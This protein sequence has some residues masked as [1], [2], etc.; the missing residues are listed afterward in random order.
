[1]R[2]QIART[3]PKVTVPLRRVAIHQLQDKVR[4]VWVERGPTNVLRSGGD[5]FVE[6]DRVGLG[7]VIRRQAGEHFKDEDSK[8]IPVD[9]FVIALLADDFGGKII[10]GATERPGGVRAEFRKSKIGNFDMAILSKENILGLQITVDDVEGVKIVE[11]E[12]DLCRVEFSD[13]I[14]EALEKSKFEL[15]VFESK[16]VDN[17]RSTASKV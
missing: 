12:C 17:A 9:G 15:L 13:G 2:K 6:K 8:R 10:W 3:V 14:G 16:N 5:A 7:L 1:M 4:R 11:C